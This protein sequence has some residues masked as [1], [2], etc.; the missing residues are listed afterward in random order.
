VTTFYERIKNDAFVKSPQT[1]FFVI[2]AKAGIQE[3][4]GLLDPGFRRG[5]DFTDFLQVH[6]KWPFK[7]LAQAASLTHDPET[8]K[9]EIRSPKFET[10]SND[11]KSNDQNRTTAGSAMV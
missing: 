4:Q 9:S 11:S 1:L 6:Q 10:R 2:P 7:I 3:Y 8:G 5:D